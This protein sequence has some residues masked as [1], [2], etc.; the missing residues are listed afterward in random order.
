MKS[1]CHLWLLLAFLLFQAGLIRAQTRPVSDP[2][3]IESSW[4]DLLEDVATAEDWTGHREDLRKR[5]LHLIRDEAK[6]EKP[7]LDLQV[8]EAVIV[9][10]VYERQLISYAVESDERAHAYLARPLDRPE[11]SPAIVALHGTHAQ[12]ARRAAG[13]EDNPQKAYLD[14]LARRGYIVIAPEHFVSGHRIPPEGPYD[15][16]RFYEK[17][18]DWTAVGKFTYEHSIAVD[19]LAS[20]PEVDMENLGALGHSLGGQGT[21]FLAA[22]DSRIK[23]AASNCAA[24]FFRHNK[25]VTHWSR[26]HWY[27]YFKPLRE[28]FLKGELPDID[29]HEIIALVA[30]RAYLD[31]SAVND[32]DPL[33]QKQRALMNLKLLD[34]WTLTGH[35]E[36]YAFYVHGRGHSVEHE[37]RALIYAWMDTHLKPPSATEVKLVTPDR[38]KPVE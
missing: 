7:P 8:H 17:H 32:G 23:A 26:D 20:L 27:I 3:V 28:G 13:L 12:G 1:P 21:M 34:V 18:P 29:F 35:P 2:P 9:D 25:N 31:V 4:D 11:K 16:T 38:E 30:P 10:G 15:T 22:Y 6:P 24:S 33:A 36:N 14:H 5:F 19:V 37:S